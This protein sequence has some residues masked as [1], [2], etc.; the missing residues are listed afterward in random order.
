MTEIAD[1]LVQRITDAD[2]AI[3][4][5]SVVFNKGYDQQDI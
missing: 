5:G 4:D 3:S 1:T 2:T